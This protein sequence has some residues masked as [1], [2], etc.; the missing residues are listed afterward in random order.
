M[1]TAF[2]TYST[3]AWD[4]E[5]IVAAAVLYGYQGLEFRML[6]GQPLAPDIPADRRRRIKHLCDSNGLDICVVGSGCRFSSSDPA[7]RSKN[8]EQLRGFIDLAVEW[9]APVVRIFG[10]VHPQGVP[11]ET[12]YDYVA[13]SI[14]EAIPHAVQAG[15]LL[16]IETHDDFRSSRAVEAIFQ[17]VPSPALRCV[18]DILH[19]Y[20]AGEVYTET[21]SRIREKVVHVHFKDARRSGPNWEAT[22]PDDG[23]LPLAEIVEALRR[24]GYEGYLSLEYEGR[25]DPERAL[26]LFAKKLSE[27]VPESRP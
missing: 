24:D 23:E 25:D 2:T 12:V 9:E 26:R 13:E 1:K 20:R 21:Y 4:I 3:P 22:M 14:A 27:L 11:A 19:P 17:R 5:R 16:A 18:W 7:E 15:V 8:V 10:G 6:A